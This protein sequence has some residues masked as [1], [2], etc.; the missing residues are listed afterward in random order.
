[1]RDARGAKATYTYTPRHLVSFIDYD[2]SNLVLGQSVEPTSDVSFAYDAGG[3]RTQMTDAVGTATYH[4]DS[5][6]RMDWESRIYV[7]L[8]N[9]YYLYYGYN[10]VGLAWVNNHWGSSVN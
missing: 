10:N 3:N 1:M 6:S 9:A 7:G 4:Y 2:T 8:Q 5:L